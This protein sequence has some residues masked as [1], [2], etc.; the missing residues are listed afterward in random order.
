LQNERASRHFA[1][2]LQ[3]QNSELQSDIAKLKQKVLSLS[4]P[5]GQADHQQ[6]YRDAEKIIQDLEINK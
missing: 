6:S 5:Q 2:T 4:L 3:K 1:E